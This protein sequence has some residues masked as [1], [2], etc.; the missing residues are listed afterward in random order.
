MDHLLVTSPKGKLLIKPSKGQLLLLQNIIYLL[1]YIITDTLGEGHTYTQAYY[2][3]G[4]FLSEIYLEGQI[5]AGKI[6]KSSISNTKA[7]KFR[8]SFFGSP[9]KL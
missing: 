4:H 8:Y 5:C 9:Q 1:L 3:E 2:C 6:L 7:K